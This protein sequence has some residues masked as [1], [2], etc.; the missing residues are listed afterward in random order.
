MDAGA[1]LVL[2]SSLFLGKRHWKERCGVAVSGGVMLSV[3][4]DAFLAPVGEVEIQ[5]YFPVAGWFH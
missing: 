4:R 5:P 2:G 1:G 3:K